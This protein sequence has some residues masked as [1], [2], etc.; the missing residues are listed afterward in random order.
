MEEEIKKFALFDNK[1]DILKYSSFREAYCK[2][3][4]SVGNTIQLTF[5]NEMKNFFINET[6]NAEFLEAP[7]KKFERC[8]E[9][10][11]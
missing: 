8:L 6:N 7:L 10:V 2:F 3:L 5:Q 11:H 4:V 9:K 1:K